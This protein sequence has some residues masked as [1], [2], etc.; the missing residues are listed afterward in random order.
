VYGKYQVGIHLFQKI[1][2][3]FIQVLHQMIEFKVGFQL[4]FVKKSG[5]QERGA[6]VYLYAG[7]TLIRSLQERILLQQ[8]LDLFKQ[9]VLG[10]DLLKLVSLEG[11][12]FQAEWFKD[13]K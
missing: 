9:Q 7:Y 8:F 3:E 11:K 5:R 1:E 6:A 13:G 10:S 12:V 2:P 4:I